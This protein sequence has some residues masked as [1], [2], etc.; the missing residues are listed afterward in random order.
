MDSVPSLIDGL[1]GLLGV[2]WAGITAWL[3]NVTNASLFVGGLVA[4]LLALWGFR[5]FTTFWLLLLMMAIAAPAAYSILI[6][7]NAIRESIGGQTIAMIAA[8]IMAMVLT[9]KAWSSGSGGQ[10]L[11]DA[12][13]LVLLGFA[14]VWLLS[15]AVPGWGLGGQARQFVETV[16]GFWTSVFGSAT[17]SIG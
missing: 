6:S 1:L 3:G 7:I 9:F 10:R 16:V 8:V 12:L 13:L 2:I 15:Q 5:T 17:Q 11:V 14:L 4:L